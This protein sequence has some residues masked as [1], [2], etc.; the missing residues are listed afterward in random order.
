MRLTG[1]V[2]QA[3]SGTPSLVFEY[4]SNTDFK[5]LSPNLNSSDVRFYMF[6]LL[7]VRASKWGAIRARLALTALP[8]PAGPSTRHSSSAT[9]A[10]SCTAT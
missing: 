8:H 3:Q 9:R 6:E 7:K 1:R 5:T 2:A 4:V 10:A